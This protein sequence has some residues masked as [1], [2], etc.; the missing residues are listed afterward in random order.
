MF[1]LDRAT[2]S[3]KVLGRELRRRVPHGTLPPIAREDGRKRPY[4]GGGTGKGVAT[5]QRA[6]SR[7]NAQILRM[8]IP[9]IRSLEATFSRHRNGNNR[10]A[11]CTPLPVPPPQGGRERCGTALH[12]A[13]AAFAFLSKHVCGDERQSP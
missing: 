3:L 10:S 5:A 4:V 9:S 1:P 12:T 6:R 11:C 13:R 8:Q 2:R 7:F